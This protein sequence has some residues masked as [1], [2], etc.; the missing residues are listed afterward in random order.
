M[1]LNSHHSSNARRKEGEGEKTLTYTFTR[2]QPTRLLSWWGGTGFGPQVS[3]HIHRFVLTQSNW[4]IE[5]GGA[6]PSV[7]SS[8][9]AWKALCEITYKALFFTE[10][11]LFA[12]HSITIALDYGDRLALLGWGIMRTE[13]SQHNPAA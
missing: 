4:F 9:H 13:P 3:H 11:A 7:L 8:S 5:S 10:D 2:R 12:S 1:S 6:E